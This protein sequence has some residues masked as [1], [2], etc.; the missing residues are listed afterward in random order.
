MKARLSNTL[1][2]ILDDPDASRELMDFVVARPNLGKAPSPAKAEVRLG[3]KTYIIKSID[4]MQR[5][6]F[7]RTKPA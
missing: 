6:S 3:N 4:A 7:S 2:K 1:R 5:E